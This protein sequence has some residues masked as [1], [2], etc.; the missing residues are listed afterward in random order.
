[1]NVTGSGRALWQRI[2][3]SAL[4]LKQCVGIDRGT[5]K[6]IKIPSP[7]GEAGGGVT[8]PWGILTEERHR[9]VARSADKVFYGFILYIIVQ[10]ACPVQEL[11]S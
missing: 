10:Y 5:D 8:P 9:Q 4:K 7:L 2:V 3:V 11:I 1:M 6:H